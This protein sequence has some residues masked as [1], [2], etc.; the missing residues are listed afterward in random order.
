MAACLIST[1]PFCTGSIWSFT[2]PGTSFIPLGDFMSVLGGSLMQLIMPLT[3]AIALSRHGDPFGAS[4]GLWWLGQSLMDL[5]PY[6][7]D[8]GHGRML[9]LG[10]VTGQDRPGYHDWTNIL[11]R[12]D[13]LG[14]GHGLATF[15]DAI[16]VV[17]MLLAL[18]WGGLILKK[19]RN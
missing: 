13:M 10:G 4:A 19:A 14:S 6:I 12:L 2:R 11:G 7:H 17:L 16:G 1:D 15:T 3:A 8:A 18:A 9:L 5:A